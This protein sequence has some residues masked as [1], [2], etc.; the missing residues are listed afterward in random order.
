MLVLLQPFG[1]KLLKLM[2]R[3]I[4]T[5]NGLLSISAQHDMIERARMEEPE[6]SGHDRVIVQ[7]MLKKQV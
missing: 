2:I 7:I 6:F 4:L 1:K 3:P 5:K